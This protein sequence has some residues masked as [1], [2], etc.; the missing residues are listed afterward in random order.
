MGKSGFY[1]RRLGTGRATLEV[2]CH[3]QCAHENDDGEEVVGARLRPQAEV[4]EPLPF[5]R[6]SRTG[7]R[8]CKLWR[9]SFDNCYN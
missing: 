3:F 1:P 2:C 5:W 7:Q 6:R 4:I 9:S 8:N